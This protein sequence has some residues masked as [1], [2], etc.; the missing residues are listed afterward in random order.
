VPGHGSKVGHKQEKAIA[1]LLTQPTIEAAAAASGVAYRTLRNW[2]A[3][4]HFQAAY[5][6]AR[7]DILERTVGRIVQGTVQAVTALVECLSSPREAVRVR[8]AAVLLSNA[9]RGMEVCDLAEEVRV[10]KE[11]IEDLRHDRESRFAASATGPGQ[12]N[13]RPAR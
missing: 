13:G 7:K 11:Q 5:R 3:L 9:Q 12:G 8:A 2:L 10:L 4:P 1:C 6:S